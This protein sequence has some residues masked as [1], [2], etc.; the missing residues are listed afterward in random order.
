[1][2]GGDNRHE[3]RLSLRRERRF[4][5]YVVQGRGDRDVT[6]APPRSTPERQSRETI[7]VA[8]S[9][10]SMRCRTRVQSPPPSEARGAKAKLARIRAGGERQ[11][12]AST[13]SSDAACSVRKARRRRFPASVS[14]PFW[15]SGVV[16][17]SGPGDIVVGVGH[18]DVKLIPARGRC[19]LCWTLSSV[20]SAFRQRPCRSQLVPKRKFLAPNR[21]RSFCPLLS[22]PIDCDQVPVAVAPSTWVPGTPASARRRH[23]QLRSGSVV[24][25][26]LIGDDVTDRAP[27][28]VAVT[29][30][31]A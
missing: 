12:P 8:P 31:A 16:T 5:S 3:P 24:A 23:R 13:S 30:V 17:V 20:P 18:L 21:L 25:V 1:M 6:V 4:L 29:A 28:I 22:A 19:Q 27:Q 14:P 11:I 10:P 26:V 2:V 15:P 7:F 9:K